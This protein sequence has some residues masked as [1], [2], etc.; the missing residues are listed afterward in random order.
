LRL[1]IDEREVFQDMMD[2]CRRH[3]AA[4]G[5]GAFPSKTEGMFLC[6]LFAHHRAL[7]ELGQ[8]IEN[9]NNLLE[10]GSVK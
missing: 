4:V 5:A 1:R 7:K 9:I 6:I 8:K 3:A 2:G 10:K